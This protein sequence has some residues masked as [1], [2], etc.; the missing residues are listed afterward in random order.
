MCSG[1][2]VAFRLYGQRLHGA[3]VEVLERTC[4]LATA[5][6]DR[7]RARLQMLARSQAAHG[8]AAVRLPL[9]QSLPLHMRA[10]TV[11]MH[12]TGVDDDDSGAAGHA[13]GG[14]GE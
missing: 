6:T 4:R 5:P 1:Y 11:R 10:H 2:N 8:L 13:H 3:V 9:S 14:R 7:Y 12:G